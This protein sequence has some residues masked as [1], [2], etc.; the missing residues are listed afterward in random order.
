MTFPRN[1]SKV[2]PCLWTFSWPQWPRTEW[3]VCRFTW[4]DIVQ[5][6]ILLFRI[7]RGLALVGR[8]WMRGFPSKRQLFSW[9][10]LRCTT[11][12]Y[13]TSICYDPTT[14]KEKLVGNNFG[15]CSSLTTRFAL[16]TQNQESYNTKHSIYL[17]SM[18]MQ[19]YGNYICKIAF[20]VLWLSTYFALFFKWGRMSITDALKLT[21]P[22]K[23]I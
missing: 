19:C 3:L 18:L 1:S 12:I 17:E 23:S 13:K 16:L 22:Q 5:I 10:L 4:D 20:V 8:V 21:I 6:L 2:T 7:H 9:L 15:G 14:D 11:G